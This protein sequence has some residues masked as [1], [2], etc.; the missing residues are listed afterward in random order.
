MSCSPAANELILSTSIFYDKELKRQLK[1]NYPTL[2]WMRQSIADTSAE[3]GE[4]KPRYLFRMWHS[5]SGGSSRLNTKKRITPHAFDHSCGHNSVYYLQKS[6]L[7]IMILNHLKGDAS[8]S[9]E[10]SSWSASLD[11]VLNYAA[12]HLFDNSANPHDTHISMLDTNLLPERNHTYYVPLLKLLAVGSRER[13]KYA[14][15]HVEYLIHGVID[16]AA[17]KTASFQEMTKNGLIDYFPLYKPRAGIKIYD[18]ENQS[19]NSQRIVRVDCIG[20]NSLRDVAGLF[21]D[22][23]ET[24]MLIALICLHRRDVGYWSSIRPGDLDVVEDALAGTN[25]GEYFPNGEYTFTP[26]DI[27]TMEYQDVMQMIRLVKALYLRKFGQHP[28]PSPLQKTPVG[29]ILSEQHVHQYWTSQ[30]VANISRYEQDS[31]QPTGATNHCISAPIKPSLPV[32][33][34]VPAEQ[35]SS[36][37][38]KTAY[39]KIEPI[40][41]KKKALAKEKVTPALPM[42]YP[43][44]AKGHPLPP[45]TPTPSKDIQVP[46]ISTPPSAKSVNRVVMPRKLLEALCK[47]KDKER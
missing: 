46:P 37:D 32:Q 30:P 16:G 18:K 24:P 47:A 19:H 39:T 6:K 28:L 33:T 15:C 31:M 17:Y 22:K 27:Y 38:Y 25:I 26:L 21:G 4:R 2:T 29:L 5:K 7:N 35:V 13:K 44:T 8:F 36:L 9:T 14:K 12:K 10:F 40:A 3:I 23:F 1:R 41:P 34:P 45:K 11:F 43:Q 20:V 42:Q